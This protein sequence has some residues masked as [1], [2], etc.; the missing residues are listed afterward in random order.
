MNALNLKELQVLVNNF[1]QEKEKNNEESYIVKVNQHSEDINLTVFDGDKQIYQLPE[2]YKLDKDNLR[3]EL[4][5]NNGHC[6]ETWEYN[7]MT[8]SSPNNKIRILEEHD[9]QSDHF[10]VGA[11]F[12]NSDNNVINGGYE[13]ELSVRYNQ[14]EPEFIIHDMHNLFA[15]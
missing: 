5:C 14:A 9:N 7:I 11:T 12:Y 10:Y 3:S 6:I 4:L 15:V 1:K 13:A 8:D 2:N